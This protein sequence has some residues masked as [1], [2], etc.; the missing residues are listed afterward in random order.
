LNLPV[1]AKRH[2]VLLDTQKT[3]VAHCEQRPPF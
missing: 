3:A 1:A 2:H